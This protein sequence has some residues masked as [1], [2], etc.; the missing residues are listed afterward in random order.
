MDYDNQ[1]VVKVVKYVLAMSQKEESF[2]ICSAAISDDLNGLGEYRIAEIMG[3]ICLQPNGP[4]SLETHV[5]IDGS[6][7]H[8]LFA[9]WQLNP[10][11]Y[12]SYLTYIALKRAEEGT[13]LANESLKQSRR[14][15]YISSAALVISAIAFASELLKGLFQNV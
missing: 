5:K 1:D 7:S 3:Q 14:S 13:V 15:N 2:S 12:F 6:C 4:D 8:N 10:E 9:K 11:T